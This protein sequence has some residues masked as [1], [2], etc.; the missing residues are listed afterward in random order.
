[1]PQAVTTQVIAWRTAARECSPEAASRRIAS[2]L[3][4]GIEAAAIRRLERR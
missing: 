4:D 3:Y 1:V 2:R